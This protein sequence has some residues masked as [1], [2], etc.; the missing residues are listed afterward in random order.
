MCSYRKHIELCPTHYK[1]SIKAVTTIIVI[2]IMIHFTETQP[3]NLK[4]SRDFPGVTP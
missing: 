4:W 3:P 2:I 1:G